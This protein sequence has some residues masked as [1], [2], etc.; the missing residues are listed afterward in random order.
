MLI[1]MLEVE[2]LGGGTITWVLGGE[3]EAGCDMGRAI[4]V[5]SG[6]LAVGWLIEV[7]SVESSG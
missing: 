4:S 5:R 1:V 3:I 6:V 7:K 2:R